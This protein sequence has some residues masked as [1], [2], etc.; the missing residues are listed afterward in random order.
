ME[1][2]IL[3]LKHEEYIGTFQEPKKG[4]HNWPSAQ[5]VQQYGEMVSLGTN[6]R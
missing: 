3:E 5:W 6:V 4:K 1:K 2:I